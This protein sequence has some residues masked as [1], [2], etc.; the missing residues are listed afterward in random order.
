[1]SKQA[2]I[3]NPNSHYFNKDVNIIQYLENEKVELFV[4][5]DEILIV[6]SLNDITKQSQVFKPDSRKSFYEFVQN[7]KNSRVDIQ[8]TLEVMIKESLLTLIEISKEDLFYFFENPDKDRQELVDDFRRI[9]DEG[10]IELHLINNNQKFN[11]KQR[12]KSHTLSNY[13]KLDK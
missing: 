2:K 13:K 6:A 1:M 9:R 12:N 3:T 11:P 7:T 4:I 10:K 5:D 8:K